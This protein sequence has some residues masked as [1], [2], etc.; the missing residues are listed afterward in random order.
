MFWCLAPIFTL[1]IFWYYRRWPRMVLWS[2]SALAALV[3]LA[4]IL[5]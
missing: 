3:L 1:L 4:S 2:L 5:V